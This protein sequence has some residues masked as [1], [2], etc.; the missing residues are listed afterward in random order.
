VLIELS[1]SNQNRQYL[2]LDAADRWQLEEGTN[3]AGEPRD[4]LRFHDTVAKTLAAGA[5]SLCDWGA[6]LRVSQMAGALERILGMS[7]QHVTDRSQFGRPLAQFQAIQQQLAILAEEA[8]ACGCAAM[9]AASAIDL[10]D[11]SLEIAAAKLRAN[12]AVPR[13]TS[14]AHQCH[15]AVGI[16]AEHALQRSTQRLWAWRAEFGTD[17]YWARRLSEYARR[18]AELGLWAMLTERSDR[19]EENSV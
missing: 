17:N 10:G 8:A 19:L 13:A 2:L 9:A 15:G 4:T 11:G 12:L 3:M 14:V 6:F 1:T 16:T 5:G 18:S 7:V